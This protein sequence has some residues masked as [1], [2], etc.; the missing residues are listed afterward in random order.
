MNTLQ[1]TYNILHAKNVL[2]S[3]LAIGDFFIFNG[4][5]YQFVGNTKKWF[6]VEYNV[7]RISSGE[8]KNFSDINVIVPV[9]LEIK[10]IKNDKI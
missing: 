6:S 9:D 5:L 7:I 8:H 3:K 2:V 1:V 4:N 10:V